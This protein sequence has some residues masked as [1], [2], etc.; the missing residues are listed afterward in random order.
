MRP[1]TVKEL[2]RALEHALC[3]AEAAATLAKVLLKREYP[4][5]AFA[6]AWE[7]LLRNQ[8]HDI[9]PG[10]GV[11]A[12]YDDAHRELEGALA[13]ARAQR[14][15]ALE[16]LSH[17]HGSGERLVV[18]NLSFDDRPLSLR[19]PVPALPELD[20]ARLSLSAPDGSE[21]RTEVIGSELHVV[22]SVVVPGLGYLSIGY[23]GLEAGARRAT[24]A[25]GR[26]A[27]ERVPDPM[28]L[29]NEHL[30]AEV[31]P[32]GSLI[33]LVHRSSGR[34]ALAG[35]G[36]Q[37][38]LYPDVP[39]EWEGWELDATYPS[40]GERLL[41]ISPP[42]RLP[43]QLQQAI[44]VRYDAQGSEVTQTYALRRGSRRLEILTAVQWRG[45]RLLLRAQTP[46]NVRAASATFETAFGTVARST[47]SNTSWDAAQFEV[48]GHRFA[49]LSEA[50]FGVSL[51]TRSKYGY[52]AKGNVLGLSLLR[53]PL[54]PD[55]SAD[56]GEHTFVYAL[57]P[58]AGD[59]RNGTL[60]EA[61]DLNAP[62]RA[63]FSAVRGSE[64]GSA[65]AGRLLSVGHVALRLSALKLSEDNDQ[66]VILRVYD[67]HGARGLL[68]PDGLGVRR[69]S[70]VDLLEQPEA[71]ELSFTPYK[72]VSLESG[73]FGK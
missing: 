48:P 18:W 49:D 50:E 46:L 55:P 67:A 57:Y 7:A 43:G 26:T 30:R 1:S 41:A 66:S 20:L 42:E 64:A 45:R 5:A 15:G 32:D 53:G 71:G 8:F 3:D 29:E 31:A 12:V 51:L 52:S 10:S 61:H 58:H 59:W 25:A 34:E 16:Q 73:L 60:R 68:Q 65:S 35:P 36:N 17:A 11:R 39:R 70:R 54:M 37:L 9:L 22:G 72:V 47:H 14:D 56:A 63:Y 28:V 4:R 21:V 24:Q 23:P 27:G 40:A 33:S 38:W 69:W 6:S 44:R 13:V 62:L 2:N 19:L